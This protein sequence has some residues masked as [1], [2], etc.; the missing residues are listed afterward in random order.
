[1]SYAEH[2][3]RRLEQFIVLLFIA[4]PPVGGLVLLY[5]VLQDNARFLATIG[6]LAYLVAIVGAHIKWVRPYFR[7]FPIVT[8]YKELFTRTK[9]ILPRHRSLVNKAVRTRILRSIYRW[10]VFFAII[11]FFVGMYNLYGHHFVWFMGMWL[12]AGMGITVGYHRTGTHPSYKTNQVVRG[13]V[14]AMGSCAMQGPAGEWMKKHTKHHAFGETSVDVHSPYVFEDSKRAIWWEQFM[15]FMHS[16]VMWAFR[17]PSLRKPMNMTMEEWRAHMLAHPPKLEDFRFREEDRGHW[18]VRNPAGEVIVTTDTILKK[19]WAGFVNDIVEIEK[20]KTV[21]LISHPVVYLT[22][23]GLS[24]Y[25]PYAL[26]GI[27]VWESLTRLL[28]MNWSTF[29][30]NSVCHLWGE[31]PFDTPDNARNNAVIEILA[32]GEGGHNTHHNAAL[33]AK[34]GV[35]GWQFD[36]SYWFIRGLKSVGLAKDLNMPTNLQLLRAWREWRKREPWM[37]GYPVRPKHIIGEL[38]SNPPKAKVS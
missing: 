4:A 34:H 3:N 19:R 18:E 37:Q 8:G 38:P 13:V 15:G 33:W 6:W 36:P 16:F 20:D 25:I 21:A 27:S 32:W 30:V 2:N 35:F 28:F 14:L 29:C 12:L 9:M 24:F 5:Q 22:I 23:L 26:G 31:K 1:M 10:A 7:R 11:P 17:E